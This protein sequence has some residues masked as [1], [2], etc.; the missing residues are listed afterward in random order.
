MMTMADTIEGEMKCLFCVHSEWVITTL[1]LILIYTTIFGFCYLLMFFFL[2]TADDAALDHFDGNFYCSNCHQGQEASIP[3]DIIEC[4]DFTPKP[5]WISSLYLLNYINLRINEPV[6][7]SVFRDEK[8]PWLH[9]CLPSNQYFPGQSLLVFMRP[10]VGELAKNTSY[11]LS[12][13]VLD[14]QMLQINNAGITFGIEGPELHVGQCWHHRQILAPGSPNIPYLFLS[15]E[16][17]PS[18]NHSFQDLVDIQNGDLEGILQTAANK[19]AVA[20]VTSCSGCRIWVSFCDIC[21]DLT[22]P[23]WP[24]AFTQFRRVGLLNYQIFPQDVPGMLHGQISFFC[25]SG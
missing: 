3:R 2:C 25:K 13:L 14:I 21:G 18:S 12:P 8:V 9:F 6:Y 7:F 4:W 23:I 10:W 24:F 19:F 20:H 15:I 11:P 16:V 1:I 17:P 5:G 22:K